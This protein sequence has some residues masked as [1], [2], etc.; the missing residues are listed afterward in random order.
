MIL[1]N[2]NDFG[3]HIADI[4]KAER[5]SID[6]E[7]TG[8]NP[9][10]GDRLFSI[11]V[12][13]KTREWYFDFNTF[14]KGYRPKLNPSTYLPRLKNLF[15]SEKTRYYFINA[16][17]DLAF[18]RLEGIEVLGK[19]LDGGVLARVE[20]N[21]LKPPKRLFSMEF[22]ASHY[23][24][25]HKSD[26][27]K[28][29]LKEN[30]KEFFYEIPIDIIL[31]YACQDGRLTY[32]ICEK[33][34]K[35]IGGKNKAYAPSRPKGYADLIN[36]LKIESELTR[37]L[38]DMKWQGM[39]VDKA[40]TEKAFDYEIKKSERIQKKVDRELGINTHSSAQL[41][42]Y[43]NENICPLPRNPPT[44]KML[45]KDPNAIGNLKCDADI[46]ERVAEKHNHPILNK[47]VE[48]KQ[49]KKKANTYYKNFLSGMD[50]RGYLHCNL[51]QEIPETYRLSSSKPNLQ[52]LPK[53]TYTGKEKYL[54]R[55]SLIASPGNSLLLFDFNQEEMHIMIDSA[56]E[57]SVLTKM[58]DD[59]LDVYEAQ[60]IIMR[61][62]MQVDI[63]REQ[64]KKICLGLAYGQGADLLAV[65]LKTTRAKA[66]RFKKAYL[67]SMPYVNAF[68]KYLDRSVRTQ[69]MVFSPLGAT[70]L[71]PRSLAYKGIN[72]YCQGTGALVMKKSLN[73]IA[74]HIVKQNYKSKLVLT[75]HDEALLDVH[76][77]EELRLIKEIPPIMIAAYPH[78]FLPLRVGI[79]KSLDSWA[80]KKP[81]GE[82]SGRAS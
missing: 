76:P 42:K 11:I 33:I 66:L 81:Y 28:K 68:I 4:K 51:N 19:I 75:V 34:I 29:W 74:T 20:E 5:L 77:S 27:A 30:D 2:K 60:A 14:H 57:Q 43:I 73:G 25:L 23:L 72:S 50:K 15:S 79:D 58:R 53:E 36:L 40:Y 52:N 24:G 35:R 80:R 41:G 3:K 44:T 16:K 1:V 46:L 12:T 7:T 39:K 61:E 26:L 47:I 10:H 22:L 54:V 78:R 8:V 56:G 6:T 55:N 45:K 31:E 65:N 63:S 37:T 82:I 69:G 62:I 21:T 9:Y 64:A 71:L 17:F 32:D 59:N 18:L 48:S 67:R 13:D 70:F 38:F 49:A